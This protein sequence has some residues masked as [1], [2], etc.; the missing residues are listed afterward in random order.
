MKKNDEYTISPN[1]LNESKFSKILTKIDI[2]L[3]FCL[4]SKFLKNFK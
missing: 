3:Q 1:I 4:N 2:P